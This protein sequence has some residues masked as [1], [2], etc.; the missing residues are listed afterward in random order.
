MVITLEPG[1][2]FIRKLLEPAMADPMTKHFFNKATVEEY[3]DFGG[4]LTR[5]TA[6]SRVFAAD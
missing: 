4:D 1:I 2:Y 6:L 3:F 5:P